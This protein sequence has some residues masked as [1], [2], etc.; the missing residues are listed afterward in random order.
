MYRFIN[1][2]KSINT[3]Y[4]L[5]IDDKTT[6]EKISDNNFIVIEQITKKYFSYIEHNVPH[7]QQTM[8]DLQNECYK[9]WK[10]TVNANML[11]QRELVTKTGF[12]FILPKT[13]QEIIDNVNEEILKYG[14]ICTKTFIRTI[15]SG[16]KNAKTWND[17]ADTFVNLNK[18]IIQN[19]LS[20]FAS[21]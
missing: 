8:F 15:E 2:L 16:T 10:N 14:S 13:A 20:I 7:L 5:M 19:W 21:K 12:D 4:C 1:L 11:L 17:N 9:V 6:A 3:N 18:K